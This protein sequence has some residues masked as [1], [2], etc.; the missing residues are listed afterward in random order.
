MRKDSRKI[1]DHIRDFLE[2]LDIEKGLS[3][4]TQQTYYQLLKKFIFWLKENKLESISPHELTEQHIKKY[5]HFLS[6]NFNKATKTPLKKSTQNCYLIA[7]RNFLNYFAEQG[8]ISLPA[9]K[10]KLIKQKERTIRFLDLEKIEKLLCAPNTNTIVGLRDR[11]ILETFFSTGLRI[12][13]IVSL[14]KEQFL[15]IRDDEENLEIAIVGKGG[16][17]RT[18]YFSKRALFWIKK[19][20]EKRKDKEKALFINYKGP[21]HKIGKRITCRAIQNLVKKYTILAGLP[22]TTTPHVLRHSFATD[23][24]SKG[25]DTRMVQEFLGHKN[26]STT[27]IYTHITKPKL[28][29]IHKKFHGFKEG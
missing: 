26:I 10:I 11:A 17:P 27:Q 2:Y 3:L 23:L 20:L 9:E 24:L 14:N 16:V 18:V 6:Q 1:I 19:Y 12:S 8:I 7:L 21:K 4:K 22:I 5:R 28:R 13:E 29:E 25:V 15:N